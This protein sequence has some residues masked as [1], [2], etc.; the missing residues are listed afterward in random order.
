MTY[1]SKINSVVRLPQKWKY[2][3]KWAW[4]RAFRGYDD[5][6]SFSFYSVNAELTVR[7]LKSMRARLNGHPIG[8]TPKKWEKIVDTIID[9]FQAVADMDDYPFASYSTWT[10]ADMVGK[11]VEPSPAQLKA[12]KDFVKKV[13]AW[14]K[15]CQTRFDKGIALYHK[16]YFNL[17]D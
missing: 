7:T 5:S 13:E 12:R 1:R 10:R 8:L 9:G 14:Q 16:Y 17:W 3:I 6:M 4:Q 15:K 11:E 2:D